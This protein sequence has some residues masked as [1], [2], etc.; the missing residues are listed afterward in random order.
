MKINKKW[1]A[2]AGLALASL[3]VWT[4][5]LLARSGDAP[6]QSTD[7]GNAPAILDEPRVA[8]DAGGAP[9]A[10]GAPGAVSAPDAVGAP[11]A[12]AAPEAVGASVAPANSTSSPLERLVELEQRLSRL[13]NFGVGRARPEL[14][15]LL[16]RLETHSAAIAASN[17]VGAS[18]PLAV[19]DPLA[20][21]DPAAASGPTVVAPTQ[22]DASA[23]S[24][25][26][27]YGQ[28]VRVS[29]CLIGGR[30]SSAV[31]DGRVVREQDELDGGIVVEAIRPRSVVLRRGAEQVE[32][33]L[34]RKPAATK[35]ATEA[36]SPS[37]QP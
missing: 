29:A 21:P 32:I 3:A 37:E 6:A 23:P 18:N 7:G 30:Q 16:A 14:A 11:G 13:R 19:S 8:S 17:P 4:P 9:D 27:D 10:V 5:Q 31:L 1:L 34:A 24:P 26:A 12:G 28:R 35:Q 15:A 36:T 2:A 33:P 25:L 22:I 20:A